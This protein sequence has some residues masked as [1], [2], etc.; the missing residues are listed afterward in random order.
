MREGRASYQDSSDNNKKNGQSGAPY[1]ITLSERDKKVILISAAI[2]MLALA[3]TILLNGNTSKSPLKQ[4][5]SIILPQAR[6]SCIT[7]L[8]NSTNNAT[9]CANIND[10]QA[11]DSCTYN[12][13]LKDSNMSLCNQINSTD[14]LRNDCLDTIALNA[15]SVSAC[16]ALQAPYNSSCLYSYANKTGFSNESICGLIENE[17]AKQNCTYM[18]YY[19]AAISSGN[20]TLC[21]YL[22]NATKSAFLGYMM[23][24]NSS[25]SYGLAATLT[26]YEYN[27][28]PQGICY[29]RIAVGTHN[30]T[31][32]NFDSGYARTLC[33]Y[34]FISYNRTSK[35]SSASLNVSQCSSLSGDL[36]NICIY[37]VISS[38]ALSTK[39]VTECSLISNSTF[40]DNCIYTIASTYNMS[41]YC[42][43]MTN[44][45]AMDACLSSVK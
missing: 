15:N 16:L 37:G 4:C 42:N 38:K 23:P 39:N 33:Q 7:N 3:I 36:K 17:S 24:A 27:I 25:Y 29:M 44:K 43:Y 12:M 40:R 14:M 26:A 11:R 45:T 20:Y 28:T 13:A 30:S 35:S 22:P 8:A 5:E 10:P 2:I 18:H 41:S 6:Y 19:K 32:C 21:A 1:K 31:I 34:Y 9:M